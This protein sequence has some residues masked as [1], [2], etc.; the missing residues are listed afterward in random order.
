MN[1]PDG[2]MKSR[3]QPDASSSELD[4]IYQR[5]DRFVFRRIEGETILVPIRSGVGDLDSIYSL[6]EIGNLVWQSLDGAAALAAIRRRIAA[7]YDVSEE[8]AESDLLEFMRELKTI[9]AVAPVER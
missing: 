9:G 5:S 4:R 7:E 3:R 6:N 8:Q 2:S 1:S